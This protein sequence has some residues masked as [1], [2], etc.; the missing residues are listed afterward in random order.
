MS[1]ATRYSL[2]ATV[3]AQQTKEGM[4]TRTGKASRRG[5]GHNPPFPAENANEC[6]EQVT[7]EQMRVT[8]A[9]Q[10]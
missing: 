4:R 5:T 10:W 9:R 1:T 7:A 8:D 2:P 6:H 3:Q